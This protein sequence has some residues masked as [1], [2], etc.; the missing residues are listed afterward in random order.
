[1]W[2][3]FVCLYKSPFMRKNGRKFSFA[4]LP[5]IICCGLEWRVW[6]RKRHVRKTCDRIKLS[7]TFKIR[8]H[9]SSG[10]IDEQ[11]IDHVVASIKGMK[12]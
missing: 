12:I 4:A 2:D 8:S 6:A 7:Y 11:M 3:K 1:M 10:N 9:N 5:N